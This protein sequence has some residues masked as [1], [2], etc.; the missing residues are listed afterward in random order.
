MTELREGGEA[1]HEAHNLT[2]AGSI[3]APAIDE[4]RCYYA[5]PA[6]LWWYWW[7]IVGYVRRKCWRARH[8]RRARMRK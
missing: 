1:S 6:P 2:Q 5:D 7:Q 3:P 8:A 4:G